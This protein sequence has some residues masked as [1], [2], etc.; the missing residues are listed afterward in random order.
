MNTLQKA[1]ILARVQPLHYLLRLRGS[2][3]MEARSYLRGKL[4]RSVSWGEVVRFEYDAMVECMKMESEETNDDL[5]I[6]DPSH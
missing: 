5:D 1:F 3:F 6:Y 2:Y 4:Q